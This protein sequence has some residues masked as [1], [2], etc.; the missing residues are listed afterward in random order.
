MKGWSAMNSFSTQR[1]LTSYIILLTLVVL[2]MGSLHFPAI[3]SAEGLSVVAGDGRSFYS[4]STRL[5]LTRDF[6][7]LNING[8][9]RP[10]SF[11]F[12][13]AG[14]VKIEPFGSQVS[15]KVIPQAVGT[16]I[17]TIKDMDGKNSLTKEIIVY[18]PGAQPLI[19]SALPDASNPVAVGQGRGFGISGGKAPYTVISANPAVARIDSNSSRTVWFVWGVAAGTAQITVT[20]SAGAKVQGTAHIGTTKPLLISGDNTLLPTGKG[21][22]TISSGNGAYTV[23]TNAN[24]TAVLKGTDSYGRVIYTLT[25]LAPGQGIVTVKDAKGQTATHTVTIRD[26]VTL[27]FPQLTGDLRTIDVAQSTRLVVSGGTAP[28]TVT[29]DN[30][31][32]VAIVQ[33]SPGQYTVT[34][35]QA[36]VVVITAKDVTGTVRTLSLIVRSL[37]TLTLAASD[38]LMLGTTGNLSLIGGVA[39]FTVTTTGNSLTL[40]KVDDK[41][42]TLTP[43]T[44]GQTTVTVKDAKGT[45]IAK[46]ITVTTPMLTLSGDT[47]PLQVGFTRPFDIKGG[48]GPYT[49]TTSN[50]NANAVLLTTTASYTRYNI[51]GTAAGTVTLT[52]KDSQGKT[53]SINLTIQPAQNKITLYVSTNTLQIPRRL[54]VMS[55]GT[56]SIQGGTAPYKVT[57]SGNQLTLTQVNETQYRMIPHVPG[58]VVIT[59]QDAKGQIAQQTITVK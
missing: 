50:N 8:G 33:Q 45:T 17:V 37:P 9:T 56:L 18:D 57:L 3:A 26:W 14:I 7:L 58:T 24:L 29:S 6:Y 41:K 47:S 13:K 34:G 19:L 28:Y 46:T 43:K 4:Y 44:P 5:E 15:F 10:Y 23:T 22:L 11:S 39:P 48:F 21:E 1:G 38:T 49:L 12:S 2:I 40:T 42:Y 54:G 27:S 20:D 32:L 52:A 53:T 16:T 31:A 25:A 36:G 55:A 51:T 30:A 59:V 35:R